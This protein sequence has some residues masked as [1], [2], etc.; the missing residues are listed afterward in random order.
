MVA[1]KSA[2]ATH[3]ARKAPADIDAYIAACEAGVRPILR[4]MRATVQRAAPRARE[5]ISYGMP[6]FVQHGVLVYFAAFR[7]HV[8][9][10]P[11]VRGD[12]GLIAASAPYAGA[13]GNLRFPLDAPIPYALI[14]R[15]VKLRLRQDL[16][17]HA[18]KR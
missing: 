11:P 12:A 7:R 16:A 1:R 3:V 10:Y 17:H 13:K 2:A 6:A 15:I 18:G 5:A 9:L 8:G 4:R 14:A